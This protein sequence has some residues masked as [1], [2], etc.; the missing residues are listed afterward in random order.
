MT[1]THYLCTESGYTTLI[2]GRPRRRCNLPIQIA[3][4]EP[5]I[6]LYQRILHWD[7]STQAALVTHCNFDYPVRRGTN[8]PARPTQ[9]GPS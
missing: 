7:E 1:F 6:P 8:D 4:S 2:D 9:L 3:R 5:I